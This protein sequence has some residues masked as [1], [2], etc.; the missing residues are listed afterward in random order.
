M[1]L[2]TDAI[3]E[4]CRT[5]PPVK[6]AVVHPAKANVLE[7]V[8]EAVR[9]GLIDPVLVGPKG[10]IEAAAAEAGIAI[11]AWP[12]VDTEHS[13]AAAEK[14]ARRRPSLRPASMS[15]PS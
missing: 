1:S 4:Q 15:T 3:L 7:A 8:E 6:T 5:L 11:A 13:H 10:K 14:A 12:I 9:A 2:Q